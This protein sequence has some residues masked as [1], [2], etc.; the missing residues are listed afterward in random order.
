MKRK[1]KHKYVHIYLLLSFYPNTLF[2]FSLLISIPLQGERY[3]DI[4]REP[5]GGGK[6]NLCYSKSERIGPGLHPLQGIDSLVVSHS[7][8][9]S[10]SYLM[11]PPFS[12]TLYLSPSLSLYLSIYLCL[13]Q[14]KIISRGVEGPRRAEDLERYISQLRE[15]LVIA[16]NKEMAKTFHDTGMNALDKMNKALAMGK[17]LFFP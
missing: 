8:L 6:S 14:E 17:P 16:S 9:L 4:R 5:S 1:I 7:Y 15:R 10:I 12:F 13:M 2:F 11:S 3:Q